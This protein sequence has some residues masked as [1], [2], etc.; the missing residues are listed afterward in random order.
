MRDDAALAY[1]KRHAG[2]SGIRDPNA[3]AAGIAYS[4][5]SDH[6]SQTA[7]ATMWTSSAS[8]AGAIITK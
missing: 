5:G 3:I 7:V 1:F 4:A 2:S 6:Q 8:S